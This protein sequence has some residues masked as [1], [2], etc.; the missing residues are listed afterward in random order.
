LNFEPQVKDAGLRI[1]RIDPLLILEGGFDVQLFIP[2]GCDDWPMGSLA[3]PGT[4]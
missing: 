1:Y 2:R 3:D 4:A